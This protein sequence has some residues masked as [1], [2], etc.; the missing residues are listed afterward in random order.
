MLAAKLSFALLFMILLAT[1][2]SAAEVIR[3]DPNANKEKT[4]IAVDVKDSRLSQKI[5]YEAKGKM[6]SDILADLS[7][8][9]GVTLKAG[10]N[11]Q[12]W[13]VRER[14]MLIFAKDL[15]LAEI[16][17]SIAHVMK[18]KWSVNKEVDPPTYRL[19]M[20]RKGLLGANK[21]LRDQEDAFQADIA[22]K[23][24]QE[25][26]KLLSMADPT[27]KQ[28][29]QLKQEDP[30]AYF[31]AKTGNA[32]AFSELITAVPGLYDAIVSGKTSEVPIR[33]LSPEAQQA[34]LRWIQILAK[35][36]G[37]SGVLGPNTPPPSDI[38]ALLPQLK[39]RIN[40]GV[41]NY[42]DLWVSEI[43]GGIGVSYDKWG[44]G[45][46]LVNPECPYN[47]RRREDIAAFEEGRESDYS[48]VQ[49]EYICAQLTANKADNFGEPLI[50]HDNDPLLDTKIEIKTDKNLLDEYQKLLA[51]HTKFSVISD[52]F[53]VRP[54][55]IHVTEK[56]ISASLLLEKIQDWFLYN[57]EI[58]NSVLE[59][60]DRQWYD[61]RAAQIPQAWL[62]KW[63]KTFKDT[64]TL[65]IDQI[66]DMT[67]L[68]MKQFFANVA[69]DD[70]L[71][72]DAF[73]IGAMFLKGNSYYYF[74]QLY[75]SLS[76]TEK[77]ALLSEGGS[78]SIW[79][80]SQSSQQYAEKLFEY[81]NPS[82]LDEPRAKVTLTAVRKKTG[83]Q[84]DYTF[85]FVNEGGLSPIQIQFTTPRY[86]ENNPPAE[87][88]GKAKEEGAKSKDK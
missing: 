8:I 36:D 42:D 27:Q 50:Q 22:S 6:V 47:V 3:S 21:L 84:F 20:D 32:K 2:V 5:T 87:Q 57:W 55:S 39:L 60:R 85:T 9:S 38:S 19:F 65:D 25:L 70:V 16:M 83:K 56:E 17:S 66:V 40:D 54:H 74:A 58:R 18:F 34:A 80:L 63:K 30:V 81:Y 13:Q 28:L 43:L 52:Y 51:D 15:S 4:E 73:R 12:D 62:D 37:S 46:A 79:D 35:P 53:G 77:W 68:T 67:K 76:D 61:K 86:I 7:K 1:N 26:S 82:Y 44:S 23:R 64:G 75:G 88:P 78:L 69:L 48:K 14:R 45:T 10:Y 72:D 33:S 49:D 29:D 24:S 59:F 41:G 71:K 31:Y 11:N